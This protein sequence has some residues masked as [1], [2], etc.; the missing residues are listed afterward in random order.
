MAQYMRF[1]SKQQKQ[2]G[3]LVEQA[4]AMLR[5]YLFQIV[6]SMRAKLQLT[7]SVAERM[8]LARD[9]AFDTVV[10]SS[11]KRE[12]E[13]VNT[14]IKRIRRLPNKSGLLF[15]CQWGKILRDGSDHILAVGYGIVSGANG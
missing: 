10:F 3:L 8:E 15:N 9:I 11:T 5:G 13:L 1:T 14:L 2:A 12:D 4:P 7:Q 6:T